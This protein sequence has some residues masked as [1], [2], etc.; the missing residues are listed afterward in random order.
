[1]IEG[2]TYELACFS[3]YYS[4]KLIRN[5]TEIMTAAGTPIVLIIDTGH[6]R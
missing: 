5:E 4:D 6:P 3:N 2:T 1:M